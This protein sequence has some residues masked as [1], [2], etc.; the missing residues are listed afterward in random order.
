VILQLLRKYTQLSDE[1][2]VKKYQS[3]NDA[4]YAALLFD[5]YNELTVSLAMSYLKNEADA[6]DAT[7]ECFELIVNDLRKTEVENFGGWYYSVV[8]NYL[9]KVKRR[10]QKLVQEDNIETRLE[11]DDESWQQLFD[12][13]EEVLTEYLN[14]LLET[15][16]DDQRI[17][18]Q[19]FYLDGKS[20]KEIEQ[21][22]NIPEKKVKS[23]IQNGK[24]KLK[25]E[26]D[27]RNVKSIN[28]IS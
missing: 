17:C 24:R 6:E 2:L 22:E 7:M 1:D 26:L 4:Y 20:Y 5:R 21:L 19:R 18:I 13:S 28:E 9:L 10:R 14:E 8:R 27:K 25:I 12:S 3:S 16:K 23:H 11:V 15:L